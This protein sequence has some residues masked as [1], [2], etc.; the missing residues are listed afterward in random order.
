[1][2]LM[3][4]FNFKGNGIEFKR[5]FVKIRNQLKDMIAKGPTTWPLAFATN[6]LP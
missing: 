3:V 6:S 2:T 5:H 4:K 1:M